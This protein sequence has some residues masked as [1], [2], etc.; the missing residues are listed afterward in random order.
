M[1]TSSNPESWI[2]LYGDELYRYA[3]SFLGKESDAEDAVQ[4]TLLSALGSRKSFS[5]N[6]S[7]KTWLF[8]ILKHKIADHFRRE[9]RY[10]L[11]DDFETDEDGHS[12]FLDNG[13]WAN[14]PSDWGQPE[15]SLENRQF[16][17]IFGACLKNLSPGLSR[18]F[19]MK[20]LEDRPMD[21]IC[22]ELDL[23]TANGGVR[24]HRARLGLRKCLER[25]WF[26]KEI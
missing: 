12:H 9:S 15:R 4:E 18:V 1:I 24:M 8:G 7:E 3:L 21:E 2:D 13:K 14:P 19:S 11:M 26:R 20:A 17:T 5:G 6:S 16:W 10:I 25:H 22:K 23:S